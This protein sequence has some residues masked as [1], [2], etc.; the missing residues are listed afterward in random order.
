[1]IGEEPAA[2]LGDAVRQPHGHGVCRE[3][4]RLRADELARLGQCL[5]ELLVPDDER[6]VL[7]VLCHTLDEG[8]VELQ[9]QQELPG[10]SFRLR[11]LLPRRRS[12]TGR[13]GSAFLTS[14]GKTT[15]SSILQRSG[16]V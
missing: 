2:G 16:I 3:G 7:L 8:G 13:S 12:P 1:V 14:P 15:R 9:G 6:R 5:L 4:Q 10:W 11:R